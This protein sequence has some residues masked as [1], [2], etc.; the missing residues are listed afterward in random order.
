MKKILVCLFAFAVLAGTVGLINAGEAAKDAPKTV[1]KA[2]KIKCPTCGKEMEHGW[3]FCP[4]DGTPLYKHCPR[5]GRKFPAGSNFCSVDGTRLVPLKPAG[6]TGST[7]SAEEG[8]AKPEHKV[9]VKK[10]EKKPESTA[11]ETVST[12]LSNPVTAGESIIAAMGEKDRRF[13]KTAVLWSDYSDYFQE[14]LEEEKRL[15]TDEFRKGFLS[16]LFSGGPKGLAKEFA[17]DFAGCKVELESV[18]WRAK[19]ATVKYKI[20]RKETGAVAHRITIDLKQV[21]DLWVASSMRAADQ[22]EKEKK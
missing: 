5:C 17:I 2:E 7:G 12:R 21:G 8:A 9:I 11:S 10:G 16:D 4:W 19:C 1:V 15:S 13:I 18:N 22:A 20:K 6:R 14:G 3:N